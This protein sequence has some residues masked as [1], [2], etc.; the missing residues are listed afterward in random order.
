MAI[1]EWKKPFNARL[2]E[3]AKNQD[4]EEMLD[5]AEELGDFDYEDR[6]GIR[7]SKQI[8][9]VLVTLV[10]FDELLEARQRSVHVWRTGCFLLEHIKRIED[11]RMEQIYTFCVHYLDIYTWLVYNNKAEIQN[12]LVKELDPF[13][14]DLGSM[15]LKD[16]YRVFY[17]IDN[18]FGSDKANPIKEQVR[19][20]ALSKVEDD[21][22][23][24]KV[25][26]W[27]TDNRAEFLY[28]YACT[29]PEPLDKLLDLINTKT[30]S[31]VSG[32]LCGYALDI[33]NDK[34]HNKE[35]VALEKMRIIAH[36]V[37]NASEI[38]GIAKQ[39]Q[40]VALLYANY[41]QTAFS[42]AT[43]LREARIRNQFLGWW[44]AQ[45]SHKIGRMAAIAFILC[46]DFK[47]RESAEQA[48]DVLKSHAQEWEIEINPEEYLPVA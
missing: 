2:R 47:H 22:Q 9:E 32:H 12:I 18:L 34:I 40:D 5:M 27:G 14:S 1:F 16:L 23:A 35:E 20:L 38:K 6:R 42:L 7:R 44:T 19:E 37:P 26:A 41:A 21:K 10:D 46:L 31:R 29:F 39:F 3:A 15:D 33:V 24:R 25:S 43:A 4:V 30:D 28:K 13:L 48:L 11:M 45:N 8:A 17:L 36:F